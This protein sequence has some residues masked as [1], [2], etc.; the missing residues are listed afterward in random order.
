MPEVVL[1]T[2]EMCGYC[3]RAKKLLQKKGVAFTDI[4]VTVDAEKRAEMT[5]RA[6]GRRTVPQI[7]IDGRHIGGADELYALDRQ[8]ELDKLLAAG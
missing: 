3:Y 2:T 5:Q 4:D 8:G 6:G 1:Y 7:F